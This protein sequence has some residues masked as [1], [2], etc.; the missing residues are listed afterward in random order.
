M[1]QRNQTFGYVV[2]IAGLALIF[3]GFFLLVPE[4]KRNNLFWLDLVTVCLVFIV[5]SLTVLRHFRT[6]FDFEKQIGGFGI[7][8]FFIWLYSFLAIAIITIGYF[9]E[10]HFFYQFFFQLFAAFILFLGFFFT[11]LSSRT[12]VSIQEDQDMHTK[13]KDEILRAL[14]QFEILFTSDSTKWAGEKQK[15]YLLKEDTRF[16]SPT[17][18]QSAADIDFEIANNIKQAY[19]KARENNEGGTEVFYLLNKCEELL[20]LRNNT[21][22]K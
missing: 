14:N 17:N 9:R 19:S 1:K 10:I 15:I 18:N 21:Y 20:K 12:A 11:Q 2:L 3:T 16:L 13:G 5:L 8:L 22:S 4:E 7:R 6:N